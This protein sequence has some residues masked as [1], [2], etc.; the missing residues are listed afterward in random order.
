MLKQKKY[1][2][3]MGLNEGDL[4]DVLQRLGVGKP[5][6]DEEW[7]QLLNTELADS[8][9]AQAYG[10]NA[11]NGLAKLKARSQLFRQVCGVQPEWRLQIW[12]LWLPL[13]LK[14]AALKETLG[15]PIVQ[16][17]LGVQGTGKT[18]LAEALQLILGHLGYTTLTFSVD[19]LYK[20]YAERQK[21][22]QQDPRLLWRGPPG[23]HDVE[24][25]IQVLD[26]CRQPQRQAPIFVPRFDK[27]AYNGAGDRIKPET[28]KPP[29][30]V[31][32]EGWFVG[33][34]PVAESV[35]NEPP[36]PIISAA[37]RQ[38][39]KDC[40]DRLRAYLPLW[41]RLDS[42][43]VLHPLDYRLSKQ[44]RREAEQKMIAAGRS[45]MSNAE[46]DQFVEY[47]WRSLHPQLFI[48]PL[49]YRP[50]LVDLIININ[51]DHSFKSV[52]SPH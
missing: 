29:D 27:S 7:Q 16:G 31:L 3:L 47:F 41:E 10:I 4:G 12:T 24:L 52:F 38:F 25:G 22:C 45:G 30:I 51:A 20:P 34:R 2:W 17:I 49:L 28:I 8:R 11:A 48:E 35:F 26:Q 15:R 21:L 9:Q 44:W 5:L 40:N 46:I 1:S 32:F 18:T 33:V 23:T 39:A 6:T 13:A 19:D 36:P 37:D 14:I 50:D 42:L 43:F